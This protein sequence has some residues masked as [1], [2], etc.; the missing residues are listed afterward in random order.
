MIIWNIYIFNN[1][2]IAYKAY[3]YDTTYKYDKV[4]KYDTM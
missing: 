2:I 4:Y 3:K 1:S